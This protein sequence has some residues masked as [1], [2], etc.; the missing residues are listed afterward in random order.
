[1]TFVIC[2]E[3]SA[4]VT[5]VIFHI[6]AHNSLLVPTGVT[7][8][9][10]QLFTSRFGNQHG[11]PLFLWIVA[12]QLPLLCVPRVVMSIVP[13]SCALPDDGLLENGNTVIIFHLIIFQP[14]LCTWKTLTKYLV[15]QK[16]LVFKCTQPG[17]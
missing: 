3:Q 6:V 9:L 5:I 13:S 16:K 15:R 17:K 7:L 14:G 2:L 4:L 1:M 10:Q 11:K 12:L 8:T